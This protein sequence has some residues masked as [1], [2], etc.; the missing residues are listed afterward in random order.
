MNNQ[1]PVA[2]KKIIFCD[3]DGCLNLGKNISLDLDVLTE[4]K[5]LIPQLSEKGIGFTLS[6]GRPQ[7]YAEAFAQLLDS[8]L[9]LVCEGGAMV[10]APQ[11]DEY[12]SM[13]LP[14]TLNSVTALRA[15]I[16][17]SDMLN[18]ELFF[19]IGKAYSLCVTGPFLTRRDHDGIKAVMEDFRRRYSDYPVNWS[20][21]TTSIDV[22]PAG[23]TKASGVSAISAEFGISMAD[24][25]AIGD[26]NGDLSMLKAAGLACCPSNASAEIKQVSDY[27]SDLDYVHGTL[28]ILRHILAQ[29]RPT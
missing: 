24:T 26:S 29:D 11:D 4:I 1:N 18:A 27:V 20:H 23:T 9:P 12:R 7:P 22:T 2:M 28:D 6:T 21:S 13:A 17:N 5:K 14:E 3:I 25:I 8:N 19:E 10:Y 16:Q 15:A